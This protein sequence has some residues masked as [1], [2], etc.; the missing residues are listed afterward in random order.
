MGLLD[1]V[2]TSEMELAGFEVG[3]GAGPYPRDDITLAL[4]TLGSKREQ[5][6]PKHFIQKSLRG[7]GGGGNI[8]LLLC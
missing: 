3:S 2:Q 1:S 5:T 6:L 4:E 7:R 8:I